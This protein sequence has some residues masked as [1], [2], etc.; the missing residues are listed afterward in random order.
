MSV[1]GFSREYGG[2][3]ITGGLWGL[4]TLDSFFL[5]IWMNWEPGSLGKL[6]TLPGCLA[7]QIPYHKLGGDI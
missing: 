1:R 6:I 5:N 2:A 4:A 7:H 3:M